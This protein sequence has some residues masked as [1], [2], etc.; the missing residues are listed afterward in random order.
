MANTPL[1]YVD[2][3]KAWEPVEENKENCKVKKQETI[4]C[5]SKKDY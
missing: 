2:Q 5:Y 3:K 1:I 4:Q